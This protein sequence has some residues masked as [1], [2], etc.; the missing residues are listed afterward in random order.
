MLLIRVL[1]SATQSF[2]PAMAS[3]GNH[4]ANEEEVVRELAD[5]NLV[6]S[7]ALTGVILLQ[8]SSWRVRRCL[9]LTR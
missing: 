4:V 8:V 6:I 3:V 5:T 7:V 2:Q 9:R 1:V